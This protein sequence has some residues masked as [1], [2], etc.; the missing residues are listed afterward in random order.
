MTNILGKNDSKTPLNPDDEVK[1][2]LGSNI[3]MLENNTD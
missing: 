2:A 3:G 1:S